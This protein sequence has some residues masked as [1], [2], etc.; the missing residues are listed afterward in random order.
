MQRFSNL[1]LRQ[2]REIIETLN[3][4]P[5]FAKEENPERVQLKTML[6]VVVVIS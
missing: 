2:K 6:S 4:L 5:E 1:Y 3:R